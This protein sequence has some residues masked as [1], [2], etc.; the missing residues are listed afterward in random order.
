MSS[1][2]G[3]KWPSSDLSRLEIRIDALESKTA[4]LEKRVANQGS[5]IQVLEATI[6]E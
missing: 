2:G 3:L 5:S 6:Q 1:I 4:E